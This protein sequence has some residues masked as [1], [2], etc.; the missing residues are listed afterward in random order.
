MLCHQGKEELWLEKGRKQWKFGRKHPQTMGLVE[1]GLSRSTEGWII[2]SGSV[3]MSFPPWISL[4]HQRSWIHGWIW[5]T[6]KVPILINCCYILTSC[7]LAA[8]KTGESQQQCGMLGEVNPDLGKKSQ[9]PYCKWEQVRIIA[10]NQGCSALCTGSLWA[11]HIL[12]RSWERTT[13]NLLL[14]ANTVHMKLGG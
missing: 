14:S 3:T 7:I 6:P 13:T 5:L 10:C 4:N 8:N 11:L 2:Q 12:I 1:V 9:N